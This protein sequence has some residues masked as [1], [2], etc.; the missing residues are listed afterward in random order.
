M[1][2]DYRLRHQYAAERLLENSSLRD[3][4]NDAQAQ[5]LLDWGLAHVERTAVRSENLTDDDAEPL[6]DGVV[7]AVSRVIKQVN[8]LVDGAASMDDEEVAE[9]LAQLWDNLRL[10]EPGT[11]VPEHFAAAQN[12]LQERRSLGGEQLFDRL[13]AMIIHGQN[14]PNEEEEE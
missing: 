4:L 1:A 10:V 2:H 13:A 6:L 7:T 5:R 9:R 14:I 8:R 3:G 12:W 11:A